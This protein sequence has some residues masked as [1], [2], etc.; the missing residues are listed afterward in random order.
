MRKRKICVLSG[1]R[2]G[3]GA[4]VRTMQL[5]QRDPSLELQLVVTDMHL[6]DKFG[7]TLFEVEKLFPVKGKIDLGQKDGSS[8]ERS[9]ALGKGLSEISRVLKRLRPDIFLCLGDRGEVLAG[10]IAANN[11]GIPVAHIQG[12]DVSGNLDEVFRHAI[13]KMSHIHFPSTDDSARRI[14]RMGEEEKRIHIVGDTHLDLIKARMYTK[15]PAVRKKYRLGAKEEFIIVLQHSVNTEPKLSFEQMRRTLK[16]VQEMGI[17]AIIVYPCSDQG[18]EGVVRAIQLY[19]REPQ[20]QVHK[21]ID[22]P[23]F[24]GLMSEARA[25]VGNSSSGIIEAPLFRLPAVNVGKRQ[26]GR[27][28]DFNVIDTPGTTVKEIFNAL[29]VALR[30]QEF[31]TSLKRCGKVYGDGRAAEKIVKVL[32]QVA[33]GS[34]LLEK[35]ITF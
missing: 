7:K 16:A 22:A 1:K 33:L 14:M 30:D 29:L 13:T 35:R 15:G 4:L 5:I 9:V 8:V 25:L 20:F 31:R 27:L 11:L 12:G 23:D 3:F 21:N 28:R 34:A 10:V 26:Q 32:K 18:Y 2:G 6:S 24:L 17:R 19:R